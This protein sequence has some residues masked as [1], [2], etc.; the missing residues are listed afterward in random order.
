MSRKNTINKTIAD[1]YDHLWGQLTEDRESIKEVF[2]ELK[3]LLSGSI[4]RYAV[5]GDTLAKYGDLLVKQTSQVVELI[6]VL[7]KDK[8]D[9]EDLSEEDLRKISE[10]IN[11]KNNE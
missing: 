9:T 7:Q 1:V 8:E 11:E 4:E 3:G 10:E 2:F 5:S 6:K